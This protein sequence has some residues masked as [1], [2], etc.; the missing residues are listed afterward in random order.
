MLCYIGFLFFMGKMSG[1]IL[2]SLI[3]PPAFGVAECS[4]R[5]HYETQPIISVINLYGA[6]V[7]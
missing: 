2:N 1:S 7:V 3:C 4:M 5:L 6:C